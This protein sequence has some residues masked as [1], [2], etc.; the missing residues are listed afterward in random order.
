MN[1]R[2]SKARKQRVILRLVKKKNPIQLLL[3]FC[4]T[5]YLLSLS[6]ASFDILSVCWILHSCSV[7]LSP[8]SPGR[9]PSC[10]DNEIVMMNHVYK[11]RFPKVS[12]IQTN[13]HEQ[14]VHPYAPERSLQ[15]ICMLLNWITFT[16]KNDSSSLFVMKKKLGS[17]WSF[18]TLFET[19]TEENLKFRMHNFLQ[20]LCEQLGQ[21]NRIINTRFTPWDLPHSEGLQ[22]VFGVFTAGF[23]SW[24]TKIPP[25]HKLLWKQS[26]YLFVRISVR[27]MLYIKSSHTVKILK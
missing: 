4:L 10:Y 7:C 12:L 15:G 9:S 1:K 8:C 11:E 18:S 27:K 5:G 26:C 6:P 22:R 2:E 24:F 14:T 16:T 3:S 17:L 20:P 25:S 13:T 19:F 23:Q 21:F